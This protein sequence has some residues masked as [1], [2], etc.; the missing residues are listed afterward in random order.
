MKH[1]AF[2]KTL[3]RNNR[4]CARFHLKQNVSFQRPLPHFHRCGKKPL[5]RASP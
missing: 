4:P 5:V 1:V 3:R 2:G